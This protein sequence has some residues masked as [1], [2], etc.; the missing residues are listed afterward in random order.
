VLFG[1]TRRLDC[2]SFFGRF[3][4][5]ISRAKDGQLSASSTQLS[6]FLMADAVLAA[7]AQ[8][9]TPVSYYPT[10]NARRLL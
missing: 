2:D 4:A 3:S 8:Q 5:H 7:K 10:E 6:V 1:Y 9:K